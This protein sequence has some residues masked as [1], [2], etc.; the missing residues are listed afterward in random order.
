MYYAPVNTLVTLAVFCGMQ[1]YPSLWEYAFLEHL[2]RFY[3]T[4]N[5]GED[6]RPLISKIVPEYKLPVHN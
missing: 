5:A 4:V 6:I 3:A 1:L 2:K